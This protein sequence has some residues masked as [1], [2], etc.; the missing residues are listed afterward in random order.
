MSTPRGKASVVENQILNIDLACSKGCDHWKYG[1]V[2]FFGDRFNRGTKFVELAVVQD[3]EPKK[4]GKNK[5]KKG[6]KARNW[7]AETQRRF[8]TV[9]MARWKR[10]G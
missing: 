3:D 7:E 6:K 5:R 8:I 10:V 4:A 2:S 1:K 9:L